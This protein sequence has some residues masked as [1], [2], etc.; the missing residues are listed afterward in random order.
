MRLI[1][2]NNEWKAVGDKVSL[3]F[4]RLKWKVVFIGY[5]AC[6]ILKRGNK[7]KTITGM[8]LL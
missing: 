4:F 1:M 7:R 6:A 5:D 2:I 8:T 3:G